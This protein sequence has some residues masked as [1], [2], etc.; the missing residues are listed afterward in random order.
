MLLPKGTPEVKGRAVSIFLKAQPIGLPDG[1]EWHV[2]ARLQLSMA[3]VQDA[4]VAVRKHTQHRYEAS[5]PDWGFTQFV[6]P[7]CLTRGDSST[8]NKPLVSDNAV[9][10]QVKLQIIKDPTGMLWHNFVK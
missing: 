3:S 5:E 6:T 4:S 2:C 7:R 8:G 1:Q 10:V 9:N